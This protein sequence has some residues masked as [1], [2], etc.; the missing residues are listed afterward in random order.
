MFIGTI[1]IQVIMPILIL[2]VIGA[3]LHRKFSFNLRAISNLITYCLMPAAVF[4]NLYETKIDGQVLLEI[5][6][7]LV[8]FSLLL[9]L[10]TSVLGKLLRLD[11]GEAAIF[12]NSISLI[13]SGNYGIPVSQ[14]LFQ[15][16]PLGISIQIIVMV[17][18]NVLT[19]TYGLYNLIAATKSGWEIIKSLLKM[20]VIHAMLLGGLL[21]GLHVPVPGFLWTP[22]HHLSDAFL[23][24]ALILLGAQLAQIEIRTIVNRTIIV[25]SMGRLVIGPAVSLL[26]I[27]LIGLDGV[28]AQSLFIASSFPTSRNSSGL[29]LEYDVYPDLAAQTV[30][31][32]TVLSGIT[33]TLVVYLSSVLFA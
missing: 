17:F 18:Q 3:F 20:P 4:I 12:K 23:A 8:V 30:L 6:G 31:F 33:V 25:S 22:I 29:A 1:F 10:V 9:I 16:N 28:V 21:N 32:S 27:L 5:I 15:A 26:L 24:I 2:V 11:K 14:L 19:Y 13:N 7:Y